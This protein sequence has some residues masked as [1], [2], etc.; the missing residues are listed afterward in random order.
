MTIEEQIIQQRNIVSDNILKS[1]ESD[2]LDLNILKSEEQ[3][4]SV[5]DLIKAGVLEYDD[6]I[7]KAVYADTYK[8]RKLGRVGQEYHRGRKKEDRNNGF[9]IKGEP[10]KGVIAENKEEGLQLRYDPNTQIISFFEKNPDGKGKTLYDSMDC[11]VFRNWDDVK[12]ELKEEY[13]WELNV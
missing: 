8:N 11:S 12:K 13:G 7:E 6:S 1:F 4:V 5:T 9:G 10:K 2:D 3:E